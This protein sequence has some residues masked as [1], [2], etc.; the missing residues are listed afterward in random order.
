MKYTKEFLESDNRSYLAA[1][2]TIT[3][4]DLNFVN[5]LSERIESTRS[6]KEPK[7]GDIIRFTNQEG[8]YYPHAYIETS[9]NGDY[10]IC[11]QPSAPFVSEMDNGVSCRASGGP[12][13]TLHKP[14]LKYIGKEA[15]DFRVWGNC[16]PCGNGAITFSSAVS[17]WEYVEPNHL[18][19]GLTTKDYDKYYFRYRKDSRPYTI[20]GKFIGFRNQD[21]FNLWLKTYRGKQFGDF[22]DGDL[23][24]VFAYKEYEQ[25]ISKEK[26]DLLDLPQDTRYMNGGTIPVKVAYDDKNHCIY[27]YRYTNSGDNKGSLYVL[28]MYEDLQI[29]KKVLRN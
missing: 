5:K 16:G 2:H 21:E 7:V 25:L 22:T 4:K 13:C 10:Y 28:A 9:Q 27:T 18:Y 1:G 11:Q 29:L 12:W 24:V 15:K 26:W 14:K 8:D 3:Q 17:V 20:L 6:T 23:I 19:D